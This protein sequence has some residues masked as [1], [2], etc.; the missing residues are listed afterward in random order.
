M[1]H[2]RMK[3]PNCASD[4]NIEAVHCDGCGASYGRNRATLIGALGLMAVSLGLWQDSKI[5]ALAAALGAAVAL[6][7]WLRPGWMIKAED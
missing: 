7:L 6:K 2:D 4:I 1:S 5:G 3:C